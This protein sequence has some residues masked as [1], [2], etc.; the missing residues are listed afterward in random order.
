VT[1]ASLN[2][3]RA[4]T[5]PSGSEFVIADRRRYA[6]P[7]A[8]RVLLATG[9]FRPQS[10]ARYALLECREAHL[11]FRKPVSNVHAGLITS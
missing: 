9:A 10:E 6:V 5:V 8:G 7:S 11:D 4:R 2:Q 3:A 1:L